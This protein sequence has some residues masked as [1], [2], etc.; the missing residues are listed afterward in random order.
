M[1]AEHPGRNT[2][3]IFSGRHGFITFRSRLLAQSRR[4]QLRNIHHQSPR[5]NLLRI[6]EELSL[7]HLRLSRT[8]IEHLDWCQCIERYDRPHTLFYCDPPYWGTEGYGVDFP[9]GNY[10]HMAEL[11]R[12][13]KGRMIISVNNI[14]EMRRAFQELSVQVVDISYNL[15]VTG[16]S[17][18][19]E[20]VD[21][22]Q[23]LGIGAISGRPSILI[24]RDHDYLH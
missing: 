2:H 15:K 13:I 1:A 19:Q 23:F 16:K 5:F 22:L 6:E 8:I 20:G 18:P 21:Y 4:A 24:H 10:V 11:A 17:C 3:E 9:I 7:A 12:C 14:P